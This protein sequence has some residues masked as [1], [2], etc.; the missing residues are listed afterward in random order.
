MDNTQTGFISDELYKKIYN[1]VPRLCIDLVIR[2]NGSIMLM[3]RDIEPYRNL[4]HLPGGRVLFKETIFEAIKRLAK[5]EFNAEVRCKGLI[6]VC[7]TI[8]DDIADDDPRHSVSMVYEVEIMDGEPE[9]TKENSDVD[10]FSGMPKDM[11]PTHG[12]FIR[13]HDLFKK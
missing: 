5:K 3:R 8:H 2:K 4:W 9:A 6:G 1:T 12:D 11:H 13:F 7:E 10:F